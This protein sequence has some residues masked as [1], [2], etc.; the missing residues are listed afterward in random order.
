M[1]VDGTLQGSFS[2]DFNGKL[3]PQYLTLKKNKLDL[4]LLLFKQF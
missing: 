4:L 1:L 3:D 2:I